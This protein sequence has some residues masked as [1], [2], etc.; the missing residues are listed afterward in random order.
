MSQ[1]VESVEHKRP[2]DRRLRRNLKRNWPSRESSRHGGAREGESDKWA[3]KVGEAEYVE[4]ARHKSA[5]NTVESGG[6]PGYLRAVDGE[7]GGGW[8]VT[9]LLDEDLVRV[10]WGDILS[11]DGSVEA[12]LVYIAL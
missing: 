11:R 6:V 3:D 8:A 4:T 5:G 10:L 7:V 12:V 2:R 1:R 9:A